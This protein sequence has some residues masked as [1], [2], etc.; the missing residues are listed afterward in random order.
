MK[1][2]VMRRGRR[3]S[4]ALPSVRA[5]GLLAGLKLILPPDLDGF[6]PARRRA[7]EALGDVREA[8]GRVRHVKVIQVV[9]QLVRLGARLAQVPQL[10]RRR[11]PQA[12]ALDDRLDGARG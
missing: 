4:A 7:E 3:A 11:A 1:P 9:A 8:L 6:E 5:K 10:L 2:G 12:L